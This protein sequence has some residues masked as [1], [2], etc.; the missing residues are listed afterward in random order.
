MPLGETSPIKWRACLPFWHRVI[1][2][3]SAD[4]SKKSP[5]RTLLSMRVRS[6]YTMRPAPIVM[7]PTSELP[8]CPGGSPTASPDAT[9]DEWG[10]RSTSS[11][12][13]GVR[14]SL[15]ALPSRASRSPHP[16][17]TRR[18]SGLPATVMSA[19]RAVE[20]PGVLRNGHS[21]P[22]PLRFA[23][24]GCTSRPDRCGWP[25]RF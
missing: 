9:R 7:W 21:G 19:R 24:A 6:W 8:I 23:A 13:A 3:M 11:V 17:R 25:N 18:T 2:S 16:S 20:S 15:M 4:F 10:K 1:A 14:A 12:Y 22:A 5:S